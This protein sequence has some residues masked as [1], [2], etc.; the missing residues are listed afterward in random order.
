VDIKVSTKMS[1]GGISGTNDQD[2]DPL[3]GF[4]LYFDYVS[5]LYDVYQSMKFVYAIFNL[6]D[7]QI[8]PVQVDVHYSQVDPTDGTMNV[9][10][11]G[12]SN[13]IRGLK[14]HPMSNLVIE[15][16]V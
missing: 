9:V 3:E 8:D 11:F 6:N 5:K 10:I 12:L 1:S 16:Q 15:C 7:Q 13:I 14:A 2:Y 4:E